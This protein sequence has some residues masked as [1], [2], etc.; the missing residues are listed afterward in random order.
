MEIQAY[1]KTEAEA[2]AICESDMPTPK[3]EIVASDL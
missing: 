2:K 3:A 1:D